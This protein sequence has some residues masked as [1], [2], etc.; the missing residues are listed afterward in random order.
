MSFSQINTADI[1]CVTKQDV[2]S[3]LEVSLII[4][5]SKLKAV[6]QLVD[7]PSYSATRP[8]IEMSTR[9]IFWAV[10]AAGE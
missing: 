9:N 5:D 1:K 7:T 3:V 6:A 8:L 2:S 4:L 10:K